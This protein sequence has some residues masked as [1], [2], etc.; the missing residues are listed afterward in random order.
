MSGKGPQEEVGTDGAASLLD[1]GFITDLSDALLAPAFNAGHHRLVEIELEVVSRTSGST[2]DAHV[3]ERIDHLVQVVRIVR[4]TC[5]AALQ[6]FLPLNLL[7]KDERVFLDQ[8]ALIID[9]LGTDHPHARPGSFFARYRWVPEDLT[10]G[11]ERTSPASSF[12][13]AVRRWLAAIPLAVI[14]A[15]RNLSASPRPLSSLLSPTLF[16]KEPLHRLGQQIDSIRTYLLCAREALKSV[17]DR[18][19]R[20]QAEAF[21]IDRRSELDKLR[22]ELLI[23]VKDLPKPD[24]RRH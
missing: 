17:S 23:L 8:F 5:L 15:E 20:K 4:S 18:E 1:D 22:A 3:L 11:E 6:I 19:T 7:G 9:R 16:S 13:E 24:D 10:L 14:I 12:E 2:D 21:L